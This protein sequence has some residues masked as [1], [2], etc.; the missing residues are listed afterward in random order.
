MSLTIA[1]SPY[2]LLFK[3][4]FG[5]S[6]GL[7]DG[8]DAL[9]V[10][11]EE[12]GVLGYGEVTLP[13][14]VKETVP[15]AMDRLRILAGQGQWSLRKLGEALADHRFLEDMPALR[16]GLH[17]AY[18]DSLGKQLHTTVYQILK[19]PI[20]V[21]HLS[22]MT[23]GI[24]PPKEVLEKLQELPPTGAFKLK[25]GD[26]RAVERLELIL[27]HTSARILLD[28][29][30]GMSSVSSAAELIERIPAERLI[31]FEQPFDT[32]RDRDS[33]VLTDRTGAVVF[34]DESLQ[35]EADMER[36][37][38]AFGGVNIK[39]MKCGGLDRAARLIE[40][41]RELRLKVMLGSMSESSLGCTAMAHLSGLAD[42]VDLDGPWLIK[43]DPWNG[44]TVL[45]GRMVI[46]TGS[47]LGI[48]QRSDLAYIGA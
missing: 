22:V 17:M 14:Y 30:Q 16:A 34:A 33:R 19:A 9:F 43:N 12:D 13:P 44:I 10:R 26:D 31:G 36:V 41:A 21:C 2:R 29:N 20:T 23:L 18:I 45:D 47:G 38:E 39:L 35:N 24:C 8:T 4:P 6:H 42:V 11:L 37:S 27:K 3:H 25:V 15:E 48:S 32:G 28:G 46:P 40:R 5:T 1:F 7:R